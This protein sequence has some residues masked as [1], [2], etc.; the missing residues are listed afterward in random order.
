M[1]KL[2][3]FG[4]RESDVDSFVLIFSSSMQEY[5]RPNKQLT[6]TL[7]ILP[8][9]FF[10]AAAFRFDFKQVKSLFWW[11]LLFRSVADVS[12]TQSG[13]FPQGRPISSSFHKPVLS[14]REVPRYDVTP[15]NVWHWAKHGH[16]ALSWN[17][18][19]TFLAACQTKTPVTC[20]RWAESELTLKNATGSGK[21]IRSQQ[22]VTAKEKKGTTLLRELRREGLSNSLSRIPCLSGNINSTIWPG[23]LSRSRLFVK[24]RLRR[25][26]GNWTATRTKSKSAFLIESDWERSGNACGAVA[27]QHICSGVTSRFGSHA[28]TE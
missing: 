3:Q 9:M 19:W 10:A 13:G 27:K 15:S 22:S 5:L 7:F 8:L 23:L 26:R 12:S 16:T 24:K 25:S 28:L 18:I 1:V 4:G 21:R 11:L 2:S 14:S 20:Y 6:R 17:E